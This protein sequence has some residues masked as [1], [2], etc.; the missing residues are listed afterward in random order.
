MTIK[1]HECIEFYLYESSS[2]VTID[3]SS[4]HPWMI[5]LASSLD[6]LS[7]MLSIRI[8]L[9]G[10]LYMIGVIFFS[11]V[12]SLPEFLKN[13]NFK[14]KYLP[15]RPSVSLVIAYLLF[16]KIFKFMNY[17]YFSV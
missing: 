17:T 1:K 8:A 13:S 2:F 15:Q 12:F 7:R 3:D 11:S 6:R 14:L 10:Q 9:P 4:I 16:C 5:W